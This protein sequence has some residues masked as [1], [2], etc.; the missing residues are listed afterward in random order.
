MVSVEGLL[1]RTCTIEARTATADGAGGWTG[2][3]W[4]T[5]AELVACRVSQP[6]TAT[7]TVAV[8][9][10]ETITSQVYFAAAGVVPTRGQ[11]LVLGDR[12]MLVVAVVEPSEP[13]YRRADCTEVQ[14]A[15]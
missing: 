7:V 5:V 4:S 11:R 8:Q 14:E 2:E 1:N 15:A 13:I 12:I 10:E 6:T 3:T 9:Q